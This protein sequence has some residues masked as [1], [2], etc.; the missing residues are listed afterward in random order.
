MNKV[1]RGILLMNLGSPDGTDT[2]QVRKYL[3]EF[4]M[5]ERVI[6]KSYLFRF[7]LVKGI[8]TPFRAR[9]TIAH[10]HRHRLFNFLLKGVY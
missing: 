8:I 2:G 3:N 1:K 6:D 4:L 9:I 10:S 5:D 7:M